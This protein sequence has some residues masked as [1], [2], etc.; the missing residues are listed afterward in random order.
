M[1]T[2]SGSFVQIFEEYSVDTVWE[3]LILFLH[4]LYSSSG[5]CNWGRGMCFPKFLKK[6]MCP[7]CGSKVDLVYEEYDQWVDA[8]V[9]RC[10]Q[11]GAYSNEVFVKKNEFLSSLIRPNTKLSH[12]GIHW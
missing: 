3:V 6:R 5:E 8:P 10:S 1:C 4:E 12:Q 2:F 11:C 9:Y 7:Q